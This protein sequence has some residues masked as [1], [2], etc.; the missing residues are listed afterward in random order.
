MQSPASC[1][2]LYF[3]EYQKRN[4]ADHQYADQI[5]G[6]IKGEHGCLSQQLS[7]DAV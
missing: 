4:R 6:V 2:F 7:V 3:H 1:P 5:K